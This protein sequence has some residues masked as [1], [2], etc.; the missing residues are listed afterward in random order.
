MSLCLYLFFLFL[1]PYE[2]ATCHVTGTGFG[3][4]VEYSSAQPVSGKKNTFIPAGKKKIYFTWFYIFSRFNLFTIL[5]SSFLI[6]FFPPFL[7]YFINLKRIERPEPGNPEITFARTY[8]DNKPLGTGEKISISIMKFQS[9]N[10]LT[11]TKWFVVSIMSSIMISFHNYFM[12]HNH[13]NFIKNFFLFIR[14][15]HWG[16]RMDGSLHKAFPGSIYFVHRDN[17]RSKILSRTKNIS[18]NR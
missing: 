17:S 14:F 16:A 7:G 9:W 10:Y 3:I 4:A 18:H 1:Q 8:R 2:T 13:S 12:F 6:L 15:P 5:I 11:C